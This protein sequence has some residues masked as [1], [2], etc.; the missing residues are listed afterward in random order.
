MFVFLKTVYF[1]LW[2]CALFLPKDGRNYRNQ[3]LL[4]S[5]KI[6]NLSH[7][8]SEKMFPGYRC[9]SGIA[10]FAQRVTTNCAYSP[11][12]MSK[13][14]LKNASLFLFIK[15]KTKHSFLLLKYKAFLSILTFKIFTTKDETLQTIV[16]D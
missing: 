14:L 9:K 3:T 1:D 13:F 11:F 15:I 7:F 4:D 2:I 5:E 12:L 10:I 16:Q 8:L 6:R